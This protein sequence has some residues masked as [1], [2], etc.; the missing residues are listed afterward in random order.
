MNQ[1]ERRE[2]NKKEYLKTGRWTKKAHYLQ[3]QGLKGGKGKKGLRKKKWKKKKGNKGV[4]E[5][6]LGSWELR[7]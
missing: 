7:T 1:N 3:G 4:Q 6:V 5:G 2:T